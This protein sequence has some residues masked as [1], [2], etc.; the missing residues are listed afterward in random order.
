[1]I[2]V[3][4][5]KVLSSQNGIA[6]A[7]FGRRGGVSTGLFASLN[8]GPGSG[9]A[10]EAVAEN[11][12]RALRQIGAHHLNTL[13]QI[14]SP[15]AV[16]VT[17]PWTRETA[18]RADGMTTNVSGLALGILTAD[19]APILFA[20]PEAKV[21]GAAHA[22]WKGAFTGVIESTIAQ[23]ETLG[24]QRRRI[25]A[26]IGP[27]IGQANYEVGPEFF[28]R[29]VAADQA[30]ADF[31]EPSKRAAHW[32]F[33]LAGYVHQRLDR[34]GLAQVESLDICTY[35]NERDYFSFRRATHA[36]E[37]DYGRNLSVI[38]LT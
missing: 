9:D 26:V 11:R 10:P 37:N 30:D 38:A 12:A 22:G 21:I 4:Q 13:Y 36:G 3:A 17:A 19:C 8:C 32:R 31:F 25:A 24:A 34:C 14:H 23:M 7:F 6:H 18:P 28:D 5:S 29:F 15:D 35:A 20:D 33:D 2:N 1:V 27:A 16:V